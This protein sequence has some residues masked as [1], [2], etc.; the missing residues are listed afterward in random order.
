MGKND[1]KTCGDCLLYDKMA[2]Y[3]TLL[4]YGR[5]PD[6]AACKEFSNGKVGKRKVDR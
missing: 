4:G 5:K 3:C 6:A 1:K 2:K